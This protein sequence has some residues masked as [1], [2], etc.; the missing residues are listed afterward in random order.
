MYCDTCQAMEYLS[1][2]LPEKKEISKRVIN[3]RLINTQNTLDVLID[4]ESLLCYLIGEN[5]I[6]WEIIPEQYLIELINEYKKEIHLPFFSPEYYFPEFSIETAP[7]DIA[8]KLA[9]SR[10]GVD[11][12]L[13]SAMG[14]FDIQSPP[15]TPDLSVPVNAGIYIGSTRTF[16]GVIQQVN[17]GDVIFITQHQRFLRAGGYF[18]MTLTQEQEQ[19]ETVITE[20][21][22]VPEE[23]VATPETAVFD[24]S[25][26]P[27]RV[28]FLQ[29]RRVFP[30]S[31]LMALQPGDTLPLP[32]ADN[33][34]ITLEINGQ[35]FAQGE[36]VRIGEQYAVEI[37]HIFH[38]GG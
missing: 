36:L 10:E 22:I 37:H 25:R 12:F 17:E 8:R 34:L 1:C 18:Q 6:P 31:E 23:P 16:T 9:F 38:K 15:L 35:R 19:D 26:V 2:Y 32:A 30:L 27:V 24:C 28:D 3:C 20:R 13:I 11:F 21:G 29:Y 4:V 5:N 33:H 14:W 7:A